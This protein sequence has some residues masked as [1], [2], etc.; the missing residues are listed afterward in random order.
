MTSEGARKAWAT[1]KRNAAKKPRPVTFK[2]IMRE[3]AKARR[4]RDRTKKLLE[5][6]SDLQTKIARELAQF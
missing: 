1:R 4:H 5:K 3:L 6:I 2:Q